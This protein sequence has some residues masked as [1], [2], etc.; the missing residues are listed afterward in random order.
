M[1]VFTNVKSQNGGKD[2]LLQHVEMSFITDKKWSKQNGA[3]TEMS[4]LKI[5]DKLKKMSLMG[6]LATFKLDTSQNFS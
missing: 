2:R 4:D 3:F 5:T 6:R 1:L